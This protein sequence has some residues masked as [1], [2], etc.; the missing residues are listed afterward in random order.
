MKFV[1]IR[2]L[3]NQPGQ[4]WKIIKDEDVVFTTNGKPVGILVGVDEDGLEETAELIRRVRAQMALSRMRRQAAAQG[5]ANLTDDEIES[6]IKGAR[7]E[8]SRR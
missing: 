1:A 7:A 8:R 3:R 4:V 6:E 5:L 2:E